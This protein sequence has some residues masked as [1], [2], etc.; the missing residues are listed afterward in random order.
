MGFEIP[1]DSQQPASLSRGPF[2]VVLRTT[3]N[4]PTANTT[5]PATQEA[6][7]YAVFRDFNNCV[8]E[9][10]IQHTEVRSGANGEYVTVTAIT[11]LRDGE[12]GVAVRFTSSNGVLKLAKAGHLMPGRRVHLTGSLG[13]FES[14]Y[15]KDGQAVP[16][17]RPRLQLT[18]VS[19]Q[20]GAKPKAK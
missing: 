3:N 4:M 6:P 15:E 17:A 8:L 5:A 13:G 1:T 16:L 12:D 7:K 19:L 9:A 18:G 11:N 20:L 2:G 10:R 14:H